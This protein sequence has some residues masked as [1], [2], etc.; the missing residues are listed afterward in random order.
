MSGLDLIEKIREKDLNF[1]IKT[2]L[3][4]ATIKDNI[5]NHNNRFLKLKI[6]KFLEKPIIPLEKLKMEIDTLIK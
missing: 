5:I 2:I 1:K 4:S 6:N 3:I